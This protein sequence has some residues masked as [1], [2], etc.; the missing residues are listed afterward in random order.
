MALAA[1]D[2]CL[3]SGVNF[4]VVR[5]AGAR[6]EPPCGS[7]QL[8]SRRKCLARAVHPHVQRLQIVRRKFVLEAAIAKLDKFH[9]VILDDLASGTKVQALRNPAACLSSLA[10]GMNGVRG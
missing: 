10:P 4:S 9:P 5:V 1:G 2:A 8:P 7:S 3:T 6:R